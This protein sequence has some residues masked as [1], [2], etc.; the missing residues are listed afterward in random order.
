MC[1]CVVELEI[2]NEAGVSAEIERMEAVD[3][4]HG[5]LAANVY[6]AKE[7]RSYVRG[8]LRAL[9]EV[10]VMWWRGRL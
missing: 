8:V 3:R 2:A 9:R 10:V 5:V 4:T 6:L 7:K 1:G